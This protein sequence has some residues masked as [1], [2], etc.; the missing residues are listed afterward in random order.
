MFCS[1]IRV[2]CLLSLSAVLTGCGGGKS[3]ADT[4]QSEPAAPTTTSGPSSADPAAGG[5]TVAAAKPTHGKWEVRTDAEGRKW[6]G[7]VPYDVFFD[8]P[9]GVANENATVAVMT[10][11]DK[12][13]AMPDPAQVNKPK[14]PP[15]EPASDGGD[16]ASVITAEELSTE[17]KTIRNF[18]N[19]KLQSTGQYNTNMA[20]IPHH[21]ATLSVLA[22]IAAEHKGDISWK[23]D[24]LYI[25]DLAGLMNEE[26][27]QRGAKFQRKLL[28]LFEQIGDTL[29]RSRPSDLPDPD[30][31]SSLADHAEIG[32]LMK[33]LD[34]AYNDL[35]TNAGS[36]AAFKKNPDMVRRQASVIAALC[37]AITKDGYGYED[38]E[39]FIAFAKT[40]IRES[41]NMV[42]S[43]ELEEFQSYDKSLSTAYQ[44]CNNCHLGYK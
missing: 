26:P 14:E 25:R 24:A 4:K 10:P 8:D 31:E 40:V 44:A 12:E 17:V 23:P 3:E 16:W 9:L 37:Q 34:E 6:F 39:E 20:M 28:G 15:E 35:K 19:P 38:D 5:G 21:A 13:T 11:P 7:D 2:L 41:R 1:R 36:E 22:G 27:L 33:R 32:L 42:D 18:L 29:N 30:P 43:I